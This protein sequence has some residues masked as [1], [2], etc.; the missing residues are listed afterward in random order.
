LFVTET[1]VFFRRY[2]RPHRQSLL[3]LGAIIAATIALQIATPVLA[4]RFIDRAIDGAPLSALVRIAVIAMLFALLVQLLSVAESW[5]AERLS[6]AATNALRLDLAAHVLRLDYAFHSAHTQG[7]L[8]ERVDGD[9]GNLARFFS[10]FV[11]N[12]VG[13]GLLILGIL[14][15][16]LRIDWRIGLAMTILTVVAFGGMLLIRSR[17]TPGWMRERQ[18][19]AGVYGFLGEYLDGLEDVRSSGAPAESFVLRRFT[20]LMRGWLAITTRAQMWGY[21]LMSASNGIFTLGLA[22]ALGLSGALYQSGSLTLGA[23]FLVFRLADML[24]EP[25]NQLRDEVQDFQQA[26]ASLSRVQTLLAEQPRITDGVGTPLAAGPLAVEFDRISFTYEYEAGA[27]VLRDISLLIEPG[28]VLG[29]VGRTGS[30]KSTLTRLIPRFLDVTSGVV[31]VGGV[32]VR[33]MKLAE[34]RARIGVVSQ[35]VHFFDASLRDNLTLFAEDE[36]AE[37]DRLRAVIETLGLGDWLRSLPEGLNTR[38]GAD[39]VGLSAGQ[40]QL[41]SCARVLLRDPDIVILDE[42]SARLDPAT[43]Q[44]LHDALGKLLSGRTGIIVA[45]RLDTLSFADDIAVIANGELRE[46]GPRAALA[47]DPTSRFAALLRLDTL[48][49]AR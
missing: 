8:I 23:V 41:I 2:L 44:L 34:L 26:A 3:L 37:D 7:E 46:H 22:L 35:D 16:L 40:M 29:L 17:A 5:I 25:T 27:P 1:L 14:F 43:E 13:N 32:D 20:G 9:V 31:R 19:S 12:V 47:A 42:A 45:H 30:G 18:A 48:E 11:I 28:R 39:G 38:L 6:W 21:G 10:R 49:H 36:G 24:R 15:L 4:G 33:E